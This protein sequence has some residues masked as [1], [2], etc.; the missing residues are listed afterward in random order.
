MA[1]TATD[2]I[3]IMD[4]D[5][6][7][8]EEEVV[9]DEVDEA[10]PRPGKMSTTANFM[11]GDEEVVDEIEDLGEVEV[12][13]PETQTYEVRVIDDVGPVYYGPQLIELKKGHRYRVPQHIFRYLQDRD[14]L[15]EQR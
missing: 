7:P 12:L 15:W 14:L 10:D 3:Q 11:G 9:L 4:E 1:Q 13:D 6:Y 2:E 8:M 5:D